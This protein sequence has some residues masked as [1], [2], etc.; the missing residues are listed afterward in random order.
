MKLAIFGGTGKTGQQLV[1][2]AL[3][4]GYEV[5]ALVRNPAKLPR[6]HPNLKG[7]QG[8]ILNAADIEDVV[9]DVNAVISVL[10]PSSNK[11]EFVISQGMEHIL[12][13]MKKHNVHRLIISAG[14]GIR[15]PEDRPKLVDHFFG[16]L[17]KLISK[18][19]VADMQ[20]TVNL[21]KASDRDWTV[22]RVPMLM[23]QPAQH[24]LKVGQVGEIGARLSRADS[25]HRGR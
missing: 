20:Q 17:L 3:E 23:D 9:Q 4:A 14:A 15:E 25:R 1:Q 5:S 7:V 22:V 19:V 18:N 12:T 21:A 13:A 6:Q 10:G 2:Q 8:D 24:S 16:V 11:P